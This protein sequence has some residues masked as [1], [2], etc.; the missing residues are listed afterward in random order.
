MALT[1]APSDLNINENWL[2]QFSADNNNCLDFD[3]S[4]DNIT[5]GDI[6]GSEVNF[7]IEFWCKADSINSG[8]VIQL[9][10]G[11]GES[12]AENVSF[13]VNLQSGGEF[14]LFY[15]YGS[16]S[17]ET[18]TTSSFDLSAD[19][20]THVAV[21]RDDASGNALFYKNGALVETESASNDPAGGDSTDAK[22]T[23]GN[24]FANSNGFN[25]E[26]A[27]VRVWN[28]ARSA[29]QIASSYNRTVDS[30]ASGLVGYWKLDEGNG[31]S[32]SDSSSNSNSG[33]ING[34]QW[35]IDNFSEY[36][37]S[38]GVA[39]K[40]TTV[41]NNFYHGIVMNKSISVRDSI[42]ITAGKSS[43]SNIK[44][45][46]AN[47]H[48]NGD[49]LYKIIYNGTNNYFNKEVRVHAQFNEASSLSSCQRIFTGR[50]VDININDKQQLSMQI[51]AHRPWD[52]I[53][54][55]QDQET[56]TKKYIPVVYGDFT[57]NE[58]NA[59]SPADCGIK[60]YPVPVLSV[61]QNNI[62]TLMPRSYGS[63]SKSHINLWIGHDRFLPAGKG[64]SSYDISEQ[65]EARQDANVLITPATYHFH[66]VVHA[67]ETD[68]F[69]PT[70][71][72]FT[73]A[74]FAFD[75]NDSTAAT[76]TLADPGSTG[77]AGTIAGTPGS[78]IFEKQFIN[79]LHFEAKYEFAD[80]INI[81]T[82]VFDSVKLAA[83]A[84]DVEV[85]VNTTI[86][87][88]SFVE[89]TIT[90]SDG[91]VAM[92]YPFMITFRDFDTGNGYGDISVKNIK[93]ELSARPFAGDSSE[94]KEDFKALGNIEY[95]YSG[96]DGLTESFTG[97]NNAIT[98][99]VDAHRDLLVRFAGLST[100]TP[101]NYSDLSN[102]RDDWKIRYWQLEPMSLKDK[103]DQLAYE[104][105]FCYKVDPNG[106]LKYIY[107]KQSSELTATETLT[108]HDLSN[109]S[110][111]TT[112][113]SD[114]ITKM[115]INHELHPAESGKYSSRNVLTNSTTRAKYNLGEKQ[116]IQQV[117]LNMYTGSIPTSAA[118]DCNQDWYSYYN[119]IVG[120]IKIIV[121]CDI[122]NPRK[123]YAL[124][125]G[126]I[127]VFTDM[128]VEMFGTDFATDKYFMIV[129]TKRLLGKVNIT[130]REV[131]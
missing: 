26:L 18:N 35:S 98:H 77:G 5:F 74:A 129:E 119:N 32:V 58:S 37:H 81:T 94:D 41:D 31:T 105:G 95:F 27:H 120:D 62:Y 92:K 111:S 100:A 15:E 126:D 112:G 30:S 22:M 52:R 60:L 10:S 130:A 48:V 88:T 125:T 43:T 109:I 106:S 42:D 21:V 24:S 45:N 59:G 73:N 46:L 115:D 104:F 16:G 12:L 93:V 40:D 29:A 23:I 79:K 65:T 113:L 38:F 13:N 71:T 80:L 91:A 64:T 96:G 124:E 1:N 17:N 66:G 47:V 57:P 69:A 114:V 89:R 56:T 107:V 39:F 116:G 67:L 25:G 75:N 7:T 82:T 68:P 19:T 50:L 53:S 6:L 49:D 108:E 33:T 28:V 2:F 11:S 90:Y 9:S 121:K 83:D 8:V 78:Q 97:S 101:V 117:N 63:G 86:E 84:S 55:P 3:G 51:N 87:T 123:G 122:V 61:N 128:P 127:V 85:S 118:S 76:V 131:G 54:F 20:W 72:M 99:G 34:A 36:I 44:I 4:D 103:L 14:R 110:V 70:S 102:D